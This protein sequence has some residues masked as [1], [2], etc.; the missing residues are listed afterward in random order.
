MY[1]GCV[2]QKLTSISRRVVA[3]IY[4]FCLVSICFE[5]YVCLGLGPQ[6]N[7]I[8][9]M[10]GALNVL[11]IFFAICFTGFRKDYYYILGSCLDQKLFTKNYNNKSCDICMEH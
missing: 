11:D 9:H 6:T 3:T 10:Y 5:D 4:F 1:S 2:E 8:W 7:S